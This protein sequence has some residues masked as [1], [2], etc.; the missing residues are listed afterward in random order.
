MGPS[1]TFSMCAS[2]RNMKGR[3]KTLSSGTSGPHRADA[4]TRDGER[5][6][7]GLLDHLLL[8]AELHRRVHLDADAAAARRF[9]FLAHRHD[10]LDRRIAQW[11]HVGCFE[12]ELL[13]GEGGSGGRERAKR[14][15]N[16]EA[17]H[18][19]AVHDFPPE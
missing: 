19:A 3:L 5:A 17:K 10:R 14:A 16:A 4:D 1:I 7:L 6:D 13:L 18:G 15:G 2:S 11:V 9:E 12:Q 8:A